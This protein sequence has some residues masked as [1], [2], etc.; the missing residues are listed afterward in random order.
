MKKHPDSSRAGVAL[1]LVLMLVVLATI[2]VV[3][4]FSSVKT[5]TSA[6]R[7]AVGIQNSRQLADIA[8]QTVIGQIQQ[9]T[10]SNAT[11]TP[12]TYAWASQ[13]GMI[14]VYGNDTSVGA[15]AEL[16]W[17]KLYSAQYMTVDFT[18]GT[19]T[20]SLSLLQSDLPTNNW[21]T[22]TS[23]N[24]GVYTDLNSPVY[25]SD[26]VTLE[27]PIMNPSVAVSIANAANHSNNA[28]LGFD[29][30]TAPGYT[31]TGTSNPTNNQAA[32]PVRWLYVLDNGSLVPGVASGTAGKV[33]VA[34]GTNTI[35][36]RVAFWT[37]DDTC[38]LN[39]NTA[40][41]G[42]YFDAPRFASSSAKTD[43]PTETITLQDANI[44]IDRQMAITP[45]ILNEFQRYVGNP[46]QTRLSYV[47]G[48]TIVSSGLV[49]K[50]YL[51]TLLSPFMQWGGSQGGTYSTTSSS[52]AN[53][54]TT[55]MRQTPYATLDEW[56][57]S[58]QLTTSG[59]KTR[60]V[61]PGTIPG[62]PGDFTTATVPLL[63]NKENWVVSGQVVH[64]L[65]DLRFF[66]SA[67]SDAP[68][69]NLFG[70]PRISMWPI[71]TG[72]K[73]VNASTNVLPSPTNDP[74]GYASDSLF[75][76]PFNQMMASAA[77]LMGTTSGSRAPSGTA[78]IPYTYYFGRWNAKSP[79][80]DWGTSNLNLTSSATNTRNQSIFAFLRN[81]AGKPVPGYGYS[82]NAKYSS[83]EMD[84][85][86]TE[87]FD[88]C[89]CI[90]PD[91]VS[92]PH[93]AS[94]GTVAGYWGM[95]QITPI[96]IPASNFGT[97]Y[98]TQG[99]G[100]FPSVNEVS[101]DFIQT[102]SSTKVMAGVIYL[103]LYSPAEGYPYLT[104]HARFVIQSP[105]TTGSITMNIKTS[106][107]IT[108]PVFGS[109]NNGNAS[110]SGRTVFSA[111]PYDNDDVGNVPLDGYDF[112]DNG[113]WNNAQYAAIFWGGSAGARQLVLE[114]NPTFDGNSLAALAGNYAFCGKA[115]Q[116]GS[117]QPTFSLLPTG[118]W[119]GIAG[120]PLEIKVY[121]TNAAPSNTTTNGGGDGYPGVAGDLVQ[122]ITVV[123]PA[124]T[125][126]PWPANTS[127]GE[128]PTD[129][130][131]SR[132]GV[133]PG[134]GPNSA[135]PTHNIQTGDVIQ[136][137]VAGYNGDARLIAAQHV[138]N[139][140]A[141]TSTYTPPSALG[142]GTCSSAFT[143]HPYYGMKDKPSAGLAMAH[144]QWDVYC[145]NGGQYQAKGYTNPR[146]V[147][148]GTLV[149]GTGQLAT[150]ATYTGRNT[151]ATGFINPVLA[152]GTGAPDFT[153][154][155]DNGLGCFADGAYINKPDELG[156]QYYSAT[157]GYFAF[158]T[159]A[160]YSGG[161]AGSNASYASPNRS[162]ASPV[163]FGS[164]PTGVPLGIYGG[165]P[166]L[167]LYTSYKTVQSPNGEAVPWQT[168]LFRPQPGHYGGNNGGTTISDEQILDWFWMPVVDPWAISTTFS[169]QGKVNMNYQIAPFTYITRASA[170]MG[171]LGSE[172]V[173]AA[174]TTA[175]SSY[176]T[177]GLSSYPTYRTPV[178]VLET[179]TNT[180]GDTTGSFRPFKDRFATG[181]I[182]RSASE[183]CD[184]YLVPQTESWSNWSAAGSPGT[185]SDAETYWAQNKL[186]GD[187]SR[188]RPYNGLYSRL[189]TKSNTFTV[190]VRAQALKQPK[191]ATA[192]FWMENPNL[193]IS[194]YRGSYTVNRYIDPQDTE[195]PDFVSPGSSP[196]NYRGNAAFNYTLDNYYKYRV[197]ETRQFLP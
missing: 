119:N 187:N 124:F 149:T 176:K 188:E 169:T 10:Q 94:T 88:Y 5:E 118:T 45:P 108:Y 173:I 110:N 83:G 20:P 75:I 159:M 179:G 136:S 178:K 63:S 190:H 60:V 164:L 16:E 196:A 47:L 183:I 184:I 150:A 116:T 9:A 79:T 4:F 86:L 22:G 151:P 27:Y 144:S 152:G 55:P 32:M 65:Q 49:N 131:N 146:L 6:V 80:A 31:S 70:Q 182:F 163:M 8:L 44:V 122:D 69:V 74:A 13:P 14:R 168:L 71:Y 41:D 52:S 101:L 19:S 77:T 1:I 17:Y 174:P 156:G 51:M 33:S 62:T 121:F 59:T 46:A 114:K 130:L 35:V 29:L 100:R 67:N 135:A 61:N 132:W 34:T 87:I 185:G 126:L 50:S 140:M 148:T 30:A 177:N 102:G 107:G 112:A 137:L 147:L 158:G 138:I 72:T 23:T 21:N 172:Y 161:G 194:E 82:F 191:K 103:S 154:D 39:V 66:L 120:V 85:I 84:Q 157:G 143:P 92:T 111:I 56:M 97:L 36:G 93:Y 11:R 162:V 106:E 28:V 26:G 193:I 37:D 95:G 195:I 133:Y 15:N 165:T 128:G 189:T 197:L 155:W 175:G 18:T 2:I 48:D 142:T 64:N 78:T 73:G 134:Y 81:M 38:K 12:G 167:P 129:K 153:G 139:D 99:F 58:T 117:A 76:T 91:E 166:S 90:E 96:C 125:N 25:A 43:L 192:G 42:T 89:R 68:E 54:L 40:G 160:Y 105:G 109:P 98:T 53:A 123:F 113:G 145:D 141:N 181:E 115:I 180:L 127:R 170:L 7:S 57:F 104:P 186:T 3:A 24:Y 171:V